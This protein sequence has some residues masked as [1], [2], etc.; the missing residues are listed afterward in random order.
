MFSQTTNSFLFQ[1]KIAIADYAD[2]F[3]LAVYDRRPADAM[4]LEQSGD[5]LP[6]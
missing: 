4:L 6:L 3:A 2:Y 5:L 1:K